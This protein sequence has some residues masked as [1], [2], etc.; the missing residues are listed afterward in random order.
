MLAG[1]AA[2]LSQINF[3]ILPHFYLCVEITKT[4]ISMK[5]TCIFITFQLI[6]FTFP[7]F[8]KI[9]HYQ[10]VEKKKVELTLHA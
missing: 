3:F 10:Q 4:G 5:I 1:Y 8:L 6:I 2:S 9:S 7:I